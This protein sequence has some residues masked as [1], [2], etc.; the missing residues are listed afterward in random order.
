MVIDAA[1]DGGQPRSAMAVPLLVPAYH[2]ATAPISSRNG[3]MQYSK[4]V[5]CSNVVYNSESRG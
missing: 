2:V 4:C 1:T 3:A 5:L